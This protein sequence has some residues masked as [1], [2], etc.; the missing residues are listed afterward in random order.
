M[1]YPCF[2]SIVLFGLL[3][4]N[5]QSPMD[6]NLPY[7]Q[8][9]EYPEDYTPGTVV[10]RMIDGLGF[11]YRWVTEGLTEADGDCRISPD[12]RSLLEVMQHI[13]S[14]SITIRNAAERLPT[15]RIRPPE[16]PAEIA[17]LRN[18]TLANIRKA[19]GIMAQSRDLKDHPLRFQT[20]KGENVYPFWYQINGPLEDAV[21]HSGQIAMVRRACGNPMPSGVDVFSGTIKK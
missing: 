3:A 21:W 11:R 12:A 13:Y 5:A 14:L 18:K 19:A 20:T 1:Q 6:K 8:I 15:D 16:I 2:A 7:E 4:L 17:R 9:P 10:A